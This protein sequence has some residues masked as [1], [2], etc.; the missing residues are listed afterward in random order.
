MVTK[1]QTHFRLVPVHLPL[2]PKNSLKLSRFLRIFNF[3]RKKIYLQTGKI[4]KLHLISN[5]RPISQTLSRIFAAERGFYK[6][7]F[8]RDRQRNEGSLHGGNRKWRRPQVR[9]QHPSCGRQQSPGCNV[10]RQD[11]EDLE[12]RSRNASQRS[13]GQG[14]FLCFGL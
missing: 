14:K 11:G 7:T 2:F 1:V 5:Q 8:S 4:E 12:M 3:F 6:K 13:R 10:G 9:P